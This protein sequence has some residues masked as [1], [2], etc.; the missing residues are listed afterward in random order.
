MDHTITNELVKLSFNH[1]NILVIGFFMFVTILF[2][3][4]I[5][6]LVCEIYMQDYYDIVKTTF[7][8]VILGTAVIFLGVNIFTPLSLTQKT[9]IKTEKLNIVRVEDK[10]SDS[11]ELKLLVKNND[12]K[13]FTRKLNINDKNT[14]VKMSSRDESYTEKV[15]QITY[16]TK[17]EINAGFKNVPKNET[18]KEVTVYLQDSQID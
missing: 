6:S 15:T 2:L 7:V 11:D 17:Q 18:K 13:I 9:E 1:V 5:T 8:S 4:S 3:M 14:I 16:S 12:G 10:L